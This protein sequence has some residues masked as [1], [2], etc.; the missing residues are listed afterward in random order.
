MANMQLE[1]T[2]VPT[3]GSSHVQRALRTVLKT[4][5]KEFANKPQKEFHE[6]QCCPYRGG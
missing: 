5:Q 2:S 4:A 1:Q 3:R 6:Q